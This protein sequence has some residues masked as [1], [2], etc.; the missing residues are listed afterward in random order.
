VT[1]SVFSDVAGKNLVLEVNGAKLQLDLPTAYR[2]SRF[3]A[4]ALES[5]AQDQICKRQ[6]ERLN[7]EYYAHESF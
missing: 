4:F 1:V 5:L 7:G 6:Q 2:V 3:V